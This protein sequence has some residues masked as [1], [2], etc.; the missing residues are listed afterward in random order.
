[1]SVRSRRFPWWGPRRPPAPEP[2]PEPEP[3]NL[4]AYEDPWTGFR[5]LYA[6]ELLGYPVFY[7]LTPTLPREEG[8]KG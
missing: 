2:E 5:G 1:M 4:M 7:V 8:E 3:V 6:G